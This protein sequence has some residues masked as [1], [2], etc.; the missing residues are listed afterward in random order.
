MDDQLVTVRSRR[1]C[2]GGC[3]VPI[4]KGEQAH[5]GAYFDGGLASRW[6]M[7]PICHRVAMAVGWYDW[8]EDDRPALAEWTPDEAPESVRGE[9]AAHLARAVR[10]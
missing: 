10:S 4:N 5:S 8:A 2:C 1:R 3:G 9:W 7:H 6:W